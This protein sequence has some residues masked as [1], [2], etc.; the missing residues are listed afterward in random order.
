M[1]RF[2]KEIE[3]FLGEKEQ[4]SPELEMKI[5]REVEKRENKKGNMNVFLKIRYAIIFA[6]VLS[7]VGV[8]TMT[9]LNTD[10]NT[11]KAEDKP[12]KVADEKELTVEEQ[13]AKLE[14]PYNEIGQ[15]I[16]DW[17]VPT[18][19]LVPD[20]HELHKGI[21]GGY[22]Y[23]NGYM[24][25]ERGQMTGRAYIDDKKPI[26]NEDQYVGVIWGMLV[27]LTPK[28]ETATE[29]DSHID[30]MVLPHFEEMSEYRTGFETFDTWIVDTHTIFKE[31]AA[32]ED[33]EKRK[34]IYVEGY[35]RIEAMLD[36]FETAR[37]STDEPM[38]YQSPVKDPRLNGED[39]EITHPEFLTFEAFIT[40]MY[41]DYKKNGINEQFA[42]ATVA[43]VNY[44]QE[45]IDKME[46]HDLIDN[47]YLWQQSA[48]MAFNKPEGFTQEQYEKEYK[49]N[50]IDSYGRGLE[51]IIQD[52]GLELE[53]E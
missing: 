27:N 33:F 1:S 15:Y 49:Q 7:F 52:M 43:Y 12:E 28:A 44:Y 50:Y 45:E 40:H 18:A 35:E 30:H 6:I 34:D 10:Q 42:M 38:G 47:I 8:F 53:I 48:H 9:Q 25:D 3:Q 29:I 17:K 31:A 11:D 32:T 4:F 39:Y 5:L 13:I 24:L 20:D 22:V 19:N 36:V 26:P 23:E 46:N 51:R 21:L 16:F 2:K 41:E 14:S 37:P